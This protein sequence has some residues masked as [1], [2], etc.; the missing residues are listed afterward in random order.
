MELKNKYT[1]FLKFKANE[2]AG[3]AVLAPGLKELLTPFF[4]IPRKEGM[5]RT[6]FEE[7]VKTCARKATKWLGGFPNFFV[8]SFDVPD[9]IAVPGSPNCRILIEAFAGQTYIPV[10]GLDRASDHN[11]TIIAAKKAGEI[12]SDTVAIRLQADDFGSFA[13]I[14]IE[15]TALISA[16]SAYF[17]NWVLIFDCRVCLTSNRSK[18]ALDVA[19]FVSSAAAKF[20]IQRF[21]VVGSSI[22]ASITDIAKPKDESVIARAELEIFHAASKKLGGTTLSLGDYTIVSPLYSEL[23]LPPEMLHSVMAPKVFYTFQNYHYVARGGS[24]KTRG[25]QQ[26]ND[27][28]SE[29][30]TKS[31]YRGPPYSWGD[32]FINDKAAGLPPNVTPSVILKPT[33][34]AHITYMSQHYPA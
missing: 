26:Y 16:G 32:S 33:I 1:P 17:A 21:I 5:T 2:V 24:I 34:C 4:D 27:I 18:L 30:I 23:N 8:D 13:L 15:L 20:S 10:F 19:A 12:N 14:E 7:T 9:D 3:L 31:F 25:Y 6:S 28:A 29:I 11:Q 22:P